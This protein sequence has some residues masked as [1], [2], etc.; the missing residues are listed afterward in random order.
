MKNLSTIDWIALVLLLV[1]G[2]NW[3]LVGVLDFN[4]VTAIFGEGSLLSRVVFAVVG[5]ATLY[6]AMISPKLG[7]KD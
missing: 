7:K 1:G 3:G 4:L 6:V 5:I 2:L